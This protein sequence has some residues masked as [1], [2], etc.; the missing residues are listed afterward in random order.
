MFGFQLCRV[1]YCPAEFSGL[2]QEFMRSV[3]SS[4]EFVQR[5][6][7]PLQASLILG[8]EDS[9]PDPGSP[10]WG[11][12]TAV[13]LYSAGSSTPA[14]PVPR[15]WHCE[16]LRLRHHE[17][18]GS[19]NGAFTLCLLSREETFDPD[20]LPSSR[21]LTLPWASID[22]FLAP[23]ERAKAL[24]GPPAPPS[25]TIARVY[26]HES[27]F[28]GSWGLFP[29]GNWSQPVVVPTPFAS[30]GW[31]TRSLNHAELASLVDVPILLQDFL[32][33]RGNGGALWGFLPSPPGKILAV[34]ADFLLTNCLRGGF[35]RWEATPPTV[36]FS[37]APSKRALHLHE[38]ERPA[39]RQRHGLIE[40]LTDE[41]VKQ[42]GQKRDDAPVPLRLWDGMFIESMPEAMPSITPDWRKALNF[43]RNAAVSYWKRY[44]LR[45]LWKDWKSRIGRDSRMKLSPASQ[46]ITC[47]VAA[48]GKAV[49]HWARKGSKSS[50]REAYRREM[51]LL[52]GHHRLED[53]W[54]P[55]RECMEK[56]GRT[57][58][59][60]WSKG[61]RLF[62]WM[63]KRKPYKV[64]W[65]DEP[66]WLPPWARGQDR[67]WA[68]DGQP[69]FQVADFPTFKRPQRPPRTAED[70]ALVQA[71]VGPVRVREYISPGEVLSLAHYFYVPKGDT[72]IRMVYNGTSCGLNDCLF[73]PHFG[74]PY[75]SHCLRSALPGY[76][77]ADIDIGEMFLNFMLGKN[78]RKYAGVDVSA[79]KILLKDLGP[80]GE[81][82]DWWKEPTNPME[83]EESRTRTWERWVRNFMG[84]R[85][86]PWRSI[87]L[88]L[89]AK[90]IAYGDRTDPN[91]PFQWESAILNLPGSW[92]YDPTLPWVYKLRV[93]LSIANEIYIYVDD[94]RLFGFNKSEC[95]GA[96][97]R[98]SSVCAQ[99]GIQDA[100][101]KRT[102][103]SKTPGPWAGSILHTDTDV[104]ATVT[105][106]KWSK[107]KAIVEEMN[108]MA[109]EEMVSRNRLEVMRGFLNYVSRTY[110]WMVPYMKC[111]HL[112]IDS[113]REGRDQEGWRVNKPKGRLTIWEWEG[114]KWIDVDPDAV[115]EAMGEEE[116][117]PEMVKPVPRFLSDA[118]ALRELT[119][120]IEPP[121]VLCRAKRRLSVCYLM[122]DAS[123]AGFGSSVWGSEGIRWESG[124][125]ASTYRGESSNWREADHLVTK[126]EELKGEGELEE[127]EVFAFTDNA[128]FEGT[129]YKGHSPSRKLNAIVLR[130]R[131]LE[132]EA[133]CILHVIHIAG[134]RMK[135]AGVDGLSRGDLMEGMMRSGADPMSYIPLNEDANERSGGMVEDWV[136]SWWCDEKGTPWCNSHLKLLTPEDW[137][138]LYDVDQPRLWIPPPAAM[139]TVLE[140][141][142]EDRFINPHI[143]HVFVIPRLMTHLWH[144]FV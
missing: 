44:L 87:Q 10:Y 25:T 132:R 18:G 7:G 113:W 105:D 63:W 144:F 130:L 79:L 8:D 92:N 143:P 120:G 32:L 126:L 123:G 50:G 70:R 67:L 58:W 73:A 141:F 77:Q 93:D 84:L 138:S 88:M 75:I 117:A 115:A 51:G 16:T 90:V 140:L 94:G 9:L 135:E 89:I 131:M 1:C 29:W 27:S 40:G 11:A 78:V 12:S 86:S 31:G 36:S 68:R 66:G 59:W 100:A 33:K 128:V 52:L 114:E 122:G 139:Q 127:T 6:R 134:T 34:G 99:L 118:R 46:L 4:V 81:P 2:F 26:A 121:K 55:A 37:P 60:D 142:C 30:S 45:T 82:P 136:Q 110:G 64:E 43:W 39:K 62:F 125:Y 103:P 13:H 42:D 49:Y 119:Q 104:S 98:F 108:I 137:F 96:A 124:N 97:R 22:R 91:N 109:E 76:Y 112:T 116:G 57:T 54:D 15:G 17:V 5:P 101:R 23:R 72:D 69:H 71:K 24:P 38:L 56:A 106:K 35:S 61:S 3:G 107:T 53:D 41:V 80:N 83:W 19:T 48:D 21:P 14:R 74:L 47:T 102:E 111:L 95:W 133:S 65:P 129:F 20:Y 85:D 28:V